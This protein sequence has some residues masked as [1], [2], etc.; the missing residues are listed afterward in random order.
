MLVVSRTTTKKKPVYHVVHDPTGKYEHCMWV[1]CGNSGVMGFHPEY[2][3]FFKNKQFTIQKLVIT[4]NT[5]DELIKYEG[6]FYTAH[7]S[8]DEDDD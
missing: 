5:L 8:D 7:W 2:D 1:S 4:P 3:T 6:S